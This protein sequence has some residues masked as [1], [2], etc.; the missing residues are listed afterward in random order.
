MAGSIRQRYIRRYPPDEDGNY[1]CGLCSRKVSV[2]KMT[3]DHIVNKR[4]DLSLTSNLGNLRPT[5]YHCNGL[6]SALEES[7]RH[8]ARILRSLAL[9]NYI[10]AESK[11]LLH[12]GLNGRNAL[13][14]KLIK[15]FNALTYGD[16]EE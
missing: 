5:H 1:I 7:S 2:R 14:N 3:V 6:R 9:R 11:I 10:F 8:S 16:K 4:D 15:E 13:I 12:M